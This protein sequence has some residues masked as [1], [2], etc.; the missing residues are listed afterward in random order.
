MTAA[1]INPSNFLLINDKLYRFDADV[2]DYEFDANEAPITGSVKVD[3]LDEWGELPFEIFSWA[4]MPEG[5][6]LPEAEEARW[7]EAIAADAQQVAADTAVTWELVD[8]S[9]GSGWSREASYFAVASDGRRVE[10]DGEIGFRNFVAGLAKP[11]HTEEGLQKA[12]RDHWYASGGQQY[13]QEY[14]AW[15][16]KWAAKM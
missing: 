2:T 14:V 16:T 7:S 11:R 13:S 5:Y 8:A 15:L 10:V 9:T 12:R 4:E 3:D 1:T 6:R